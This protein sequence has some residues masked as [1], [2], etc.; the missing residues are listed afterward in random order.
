MNMNYF[1]WA[2]NTIIGI[3]FFYA[4][5][6][7]NKVNDVEDDLKIALEMSGNNRP[8][9][10]KVLEHYSKNREDSLKLKAAQFLIKNMTYHQFASGKFMNQCI[11]QID[12]SYSDLSNATRMGYYTIP[13][14]IDSLKEKIE[15]KNDIK[16]ITADY[17]IANIE[18]SFA[19]RE[20]HNFLPELSF[21]NFCESIL[22]YKLSLEPLKMWKDSSLSKKYDEKIKKY[23]FNLSLYYK[24]IKALS[25]DYTP[26]H[27]IWLEGPLTY[28]HNSQARAYIETFIMRSYGIPMIIDFIPFNQKDNYWTSIIDEKY[29]GYTKRTWEVQYNDIVK[30]IMTPKVFRKTYSM[31]NIPKDEDN[32]IPDFIQN[33]YNKD[34]TEQYR[35]VTTVK[36]D[37]GEIPSNIKYGYLSFFDNYDWKEIAWGKLN[38]GEVLFEKMGRGVVYI[39]TYY[40]KTKKVNG[41]YPITIDDTGT[42]SELKPDKNNVIETINLT[43][44]YSASTDGEAEGRKLINAKILA[45]NE[46]GFDHLDSITKISHYKNMM[47]DTVNTNCDRKYKTWILQTDNYNSANLSEIHFFDEFDHQLVGEYFVLRNKEISAVVA[48]RIGD[49]DLS[50]YLILNFEV[51]INF[52]TSKTVKYIK[53]SNMVDGKGVYPGNSYELFYFDEGNWVSLGKKVATDFSITYENIPQNALFWLRDLTTK[54]DERPFTI[55][56][57]K[58]KFW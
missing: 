32:F 8:E 9:L 3:C 42:L 53:Y 33:R 40:D 28:R 26:R 38:D 44:R 46:Q 57:G 15:L 56:N 34:V 14:S 45:T 30:R 27:S 1:Q 4:A 49:M 10:E 55:V 21:D 7:C 23:D 41:K 11:V 17:L 25:D 35:N 39:P 16:E 24:Y 50:T 48:S 29:I 18:A 43:R 20:K 37:F 5:V 47:Y 6:S 22:P 58:I 52:K 12:S 31:N 2:K 19:I 54:S 51:G 13:T 36:Y